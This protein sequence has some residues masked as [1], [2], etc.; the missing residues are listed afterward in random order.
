MI[1]LLPLLAA[2]TVAAPGSEVVVVLDNSGSMAM[3]FRDQDGNTLPP[4]DPGR[5]AVLGTLIV[6]GLARGS[7][8]RVTVVAFGERAD[9]PP[10]VVTTAD[11]I[12]ALPF[13]GGTFF[14][15]ALEEAGRRL[16]SSS[17]PTRLFLFLT[18]GA[19]TDIQS[20]DEAARALGLGDERIFETLVLGL[21]ASDDS[22]QI[23]EP[24]LR[25]LVRDPADLVFLRDPREVVPAFTRGFARV[26]GSR[27]ESGVLEE[28]DTKTFDVGKYVTEV[29]VF[30]ASS[31]PGPP[32]VATLQ[33]PSGPVPVRA[34]G[35]NRCPRGNMPPGLCD[36][37]GRHYQVFRAPND[38][39]AASRWTLSL[40]AAPD[41]VEYG[42][43]LRYDLT[44]SLTL[45]ATVQ[46]GDAVPVEARLLFRAQPFDDA[47]FFAAD[48][49][50]ATAR[51][52]GEELPLEH[53]GG[54]LFRGTWTPRTPG[55]DPL[56]A[57]VRFRNAWME[58]V[59]R[60]PV[61]VE[62]YLE[63]SLRVSP[64]PLALG[65]WR[66]ERS[67][68]R[69]CGVLDLSGSRNADRVPLACTGVGRLAQGAMTCAP[70]PGSEAPLPGGRKGQPQRWEVC[71]DVPG[72]CGDAA[73]R[74]GD[75]VAVRLAGADPHYAAGAVTVP[76]HFLV[77][78]TGFL[79]CWWIELA[80]GLLGLFGMFV[81]AGI[82]RPHSFDPAATVTVAG[83]ELGLRR[84]AATVLAEAPGGV[85]GFYRNAR[86]AISA[87][88]DLLRNPRLA[89][90]VV[91]ATRG[92][93][94]FRKAPGLQRKIQRTGT[95]EDVP[96]G[97]FEQGFLPGTV[98]RLGNLFL[99]FG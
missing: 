28:G 89:V 55:D 16:T 9:G 61:R 50:T 99:K 63:L 96:P 4:N 18:D 12:R 54:G 5:S 1:A 3:S 82:V 57:E 98:Y 49:F 41:E 77:E 81:I 17:Q 13:S 90:L 31:R 19:P 45:P 78:R 85:R 32:F 69:R 66:G 56:A 46:V 7:G 15:R 11:D 74:A 25:T 91:E 39:A 88:G 6:E 38:P 30:V 2:A 29:L 67:G 79:R 60:K 68:T 36:G 27:P 34:A 52:D 40:P 51:I 20:I 23:G 42:V 73:S 86:L 24:I 8:D 93:S 53:A 21:Y 70:V 14:R 71:L 72:C 33:G 75:E 84:A 48:G 76:V 65:T 92:G 62:G 97:E 22:R 83:S 59:D 87:D 80:A 10:Y 47:A 95:W 64:S 58:K 44:P 43:I 37:P 35:D 26:L 94:R